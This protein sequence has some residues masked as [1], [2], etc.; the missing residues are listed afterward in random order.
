MSHPDL[1]VGSDTADD[2]A[3]WRRPEGR[4][5]I[6]TTDFFTPIVDDPRV[7]GRIAAANA[8]SDVFAMGGTPLFG[9]N[10]VAWPR[11]DLSLDLLT[12]VLAGGAEIAADGGWVVVGGHT[13]DGPEP[14]YGQVITGEV[15]VEAVL[16]NAGGEV[17]Q[18]MVLT[19]AIGTGLVATAVKRSDR[20]A[21]A[22]GGE[23]SALYEAAVAAMTTLNA[24]AADVAHR[25]GTTAATDVTG[26][27]LLGHLYRLAYASGVAAVVEAGTVPV[28]DGAWALIDAGYVPGGTRRNVDFVADHLVGEAPESATLTMLADAQTSGGLLFACESE[29][30]IDA[31]G[32]LVAAGH[33]AAVI[34]GLVEGPPGAM[35]V[36]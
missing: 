16:T 11:D 2:A 13:V 7:W 9:L 22:P 31:V 30:A 8:V 4:A 17:G 24:T 14:M 5:L 18:S 10:L 36:I 3:V 34:G 35:T 26:F 21:V 33:R 1:L 23:L 28:F 12:S 27:G 6:S 19:K 29:A 20:A 32:E 25:H 15:D